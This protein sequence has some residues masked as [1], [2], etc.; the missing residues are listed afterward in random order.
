MKKVLTMWA[1]L[2]CAVGFAQKPKEIQEPDVTIAVGQKYTWV[3]KFAAGTELE[4]DT[5]DDNDED[6]VKITPD[7]TK[8]I[9]KGL[10]VGDA[11]VLCTD[12]KTVYHRTVH[13]V[14]RGAQTKDGEEVGEEETFTGKYAYNPPK[15]HYYI[16][17]GSFIYARIG[18]EQIEK[19]IDKKGNLEYWMYYNLAAREC[20]QYLEKDGFDHGKVDNEELEPEEWKARENLALLDAFADSE[21]WKSIKSD[22]VNA[23]GDYYVGSEY[24]CGVKCWVFDT[25]GYAGISMKYWVDPS[26]GCCLKYEGRGNGGAVRSA[27]EVK[28]YNLNYRTW[29]SDVYDATIKR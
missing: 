19:C 13:V 16:H 26:N 9:I 12:S 4:F 2:L 17:T 11:I 3:T 22:P 23:L 18:S 27:M 20:K 25:D 29:T 7:G 24:V 10:S 1:V 6:A 28:T 15:D 8:C 5:L 14:A 21:F